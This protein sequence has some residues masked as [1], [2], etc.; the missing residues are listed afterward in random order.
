MNAQT[1]ARPSPQRTALVVGSDNELAGT[2]SSILGAW[3]I[4]RATNN[5]AA[6]AMT[7]SHPYDLF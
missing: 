4:E 3:H 1:D 7:E 5:L 6:L 2:V